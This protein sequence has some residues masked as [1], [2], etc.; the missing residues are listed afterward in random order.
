MMAGVD[1]YA[2]GSVPVWEREWCD[3]LLGVNREMTTN[4]PICLAN[5]PGNQCECSGKPLRMVRE[6]TANAPGSHCER[7]GKPQ[8]TH[9]YA[10]GKAR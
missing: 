10:F 1:R 8:R 3:I 6:T 5:E 4:R 7:A 9:R 2:F